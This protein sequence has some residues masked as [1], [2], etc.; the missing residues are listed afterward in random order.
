MQTGFV[1]P[2]L[3]Q[4]FVPSGLAL[5]FVTREGCEHSLCEPESENG[6][7][8]LHPDI[9]CDF[10]VNTLRSS[11]IPSELA[12]RLEIF[13][14]YLFA[15][16]ELKL[17]L[18][19]T[20]GDVIAVSLRHLLADENWERTSIGQ[21]ES[22]CWPVLCANCVETFACEQLFRDHL[23]GTV[24]ISVNEIE[25]RCDLVVNSEA[26]V[27]SVWCKKEMDDRS[28]VE[29][30][31]MFERPLAHLRSRH[32]LTRSRLE[33]IESWRRV[34]MHRLATFE[35]PLTILHLDERGSRED[36][37]SC[38]LDSVTLFLVHVHKIFGKVL[39]AS[40]LNDVDNFVWGETTIKH[41]S[42]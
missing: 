2:Q 25:C 37:C 39:K 6:L 40:F 3:P 20:I 14:E 31:A 7:G 5:K 38:Y 34:D 15:V 16:D 13:N 18:Q 33:E 9:Y 22:C 4:H 10:T 28:Q 12:Q 26:L 30:L 17:W 42:L 19:K 23:S 36:I 41:V 21:Q 29:T 32:E 27:R 11:T 24:G 1:L 8:F 35:L